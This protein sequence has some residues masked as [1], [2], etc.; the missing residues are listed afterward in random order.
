VIRV[1]VRLTD[2]DHRILENRVLRSL[3]LFFVVLALAVVAAQNGYAQDKSQEPKIV[4]QLEKP[5]AGDN[6]RRLLGPFGATCK[7]VKQEN[8]KE[9]GSY[10]PGWDK[11][12]SIA[13]WMGAPLE[14]VK[15]RRYGPGW[16]KSD[17]VRKRVASL[18]KTQSGEVYPYE[19]WAEGVFQDI[20]AT[21]QFSDHAE[22]NLEVSGV[23]VCFSN[24]S[25]TALWLR[26]L[27]TK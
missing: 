14:E 22:G 3:Q 11:P 10:H 6:P 1:R 13:A 20:V 18:L 17:D 4:L 5:V 24:H 9:R 12:V 16:K 19:P 7:S 21:I 15:I 2:R 26:V 23:H 25:G 8:G 27:P